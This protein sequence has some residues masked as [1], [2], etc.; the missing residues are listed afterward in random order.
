MKDTLNV[1]SFFSGC[2]GFDLGFKKAGYNIILANDFWEPAVHS[3]KINFPE[4]ELL[5]KD[6]KNIKKEEL[7][8]ILKKKNVKKI[9]VVI[10]GPPCR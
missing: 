1:M 2:G 8:S 10:G 3:Y 4:T 7:L 9:D 5:Q 6:I